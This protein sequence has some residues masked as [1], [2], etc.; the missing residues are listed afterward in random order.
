MPNGL[1]AQ[2]RLL[3]PTARLDDFVHKPH[4]IKMDVEGG[5]SKALMG[6]RR[7]IESARPILF[8]ALQGR[9]QVECV[10]AILR[11]FRYEKF[12]LEGNPRDA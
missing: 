2:S 3:V 4:L 10:T 11:D 1:V 7:L 5:E 12:S 6:A 8:V 9:E